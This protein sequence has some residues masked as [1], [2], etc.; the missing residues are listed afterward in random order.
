MFQALP[1]QTNLFDRPVVIRWASSGDARAVR[2]LAVLDSASPLDGEVLVA[3][4][5]DEPWA[6]ISVE[7]GRVVADPFRPSADAAALLRMRAEH[8]RAALSARRSPRR[9]LRPRRA[10]A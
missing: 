9:S 7:D 3:F 8:L 2:D 5:D 1:T 6:A 10:S 4:V